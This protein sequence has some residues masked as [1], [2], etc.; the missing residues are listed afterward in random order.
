MS[1]VRIPLPPKVRHFEIVGQ[2]HRLPFP[3]ASDGLCPVIGSDGQTKKAG[4]HELSGFSNLSATPELCVTVL[5]SLSLGFFRF[6]GLN[7]MSEIPK[8][9]GVSRRPSASDKF[10]ILNFNISDFQDFSFCLQR[11]SLERR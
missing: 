1:G 7:G 10:F 5:Y 8:N 3:S 4:Q 2:A 6:R 9:F 11:F